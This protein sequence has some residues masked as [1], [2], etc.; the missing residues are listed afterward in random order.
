LL[1]GFLEKKILLLTCLLIFVYTIGLLTPKV[2]SIFDAASNLDGWIGVLR[3]VDKSSYESK[4]I[5]DYHRTQSRFEE[6]VSALNPLVTIWPAAQLFVRI[7]LVFMFFRN[8]MSSAS[9][10]GYLTHLKSGQM[11]RGMEWLRGPDLRAVNLSLKALQKISLKKEVNRKAPMTLA[12]MR[13]LEGF[14]DFHVRADVEY[15]VL[16]RVCHDALLRGGEG[17]KIHFRHL[18]WSS[19]RGR[20]RLSIHGSK[21]N[22]KGPVELIDLVDW[23]EESAVCYIRNYLTYSTYGRLSRTI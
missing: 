12:K 3:E 14:L 7:F 10:P 11:D 9:L 22:K 23:G 19:D 5:V 15:A 4:T 20:L 13:I 8:K 18:A 1:S 2:P 6:F 16:S 17:I 21:C